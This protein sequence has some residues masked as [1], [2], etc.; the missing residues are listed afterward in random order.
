VIGGLGN[1]AGHAHRFFRATET[2][3]MNRLQVPNEFSAVTGACM[4]TRRS[5]YE[6][7]GGLNSKDL[8]VAYNDVDYCLRVKEK[9]YRIVYAPQAELFHFESKTRGREETSEKKQR[10]S[11]ERAYMWEHWRLEL[12]DDEFYNPNLSRVREDFS[13]SNK[14][15]SMSNTQ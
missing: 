6:T 7:L 8:A 15:H 4:L 14:P 13:I 3:Y 9:G 12:E 11:Q 5:L 2:G 1:V 10:Y